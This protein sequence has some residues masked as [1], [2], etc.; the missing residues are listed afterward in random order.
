M[1]SVLT[2]SNENKLSNHG[3]GDNKLSAGHN[4]LTL[5]QKTSKDKKNAN[6]SVNWYMT[7][8]VQ[9]IH[10]HRHS[11]NQMIYCLYIVPSS[12]QAVLTNTW[13]QFQCLFLQIQPL[14]SHIFLAIFYFQLEHNIEP[15][16][17]ISNNVVCATSKGSIW[18]EP[19][20]VA[21]KFYD[22]SSLKDGCTDMLVWVYTCQNTT[23]FEIACRSSL[24]WCS[25]EWDASND[26]TTYN[27]YYLRN[28]KYRY[29]DIPL[30]TN[31]LLLKYLTWVP[32]KNL[33]SLPTSVICW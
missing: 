31:P 12:C 23:L 1:K 29:V 28:M 32:S 8:P 24:L 14:A 17:E 20:L 6:L 33:N 15:R 2:I 7:T 9:A 27:M 10:S 3:T 25:N 5:S 22:L 19:L 26:H 11:Q 21:W 16:H 13:H 30:I 4:Q 18:S